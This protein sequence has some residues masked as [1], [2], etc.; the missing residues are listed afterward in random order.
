MNRQMNKC[1]A[2]L[3]VLLMVMMCS[4]VLV[5][6]L[7]HKPEQVPGMIHVKFKHGEIVEVKKTLNLEDIK[8]R[9]L[10][11]IFSH[12]KFKEARKIFKSAVP[13]KSMAKSRTGEWVALKDL[14]H[15]YEV[16]VDDGS[17]IQSILEELKGDERIESVSPV[18]Y[19]YPM[20]NP[21]N[22]SYFYYQ[23]GLKNGTSGRDIHAV[24]A[25]NYNTG[26]SNV[27]I[28]VIDGG[29]DYNHE[30][31]DPGN[32][33]RVIAGY[34][35][36]NNDS[37]PIDDI[38]S[39]EGFAGHGTL[40]AGVIGAM[41]D[42]N[43]GVAGIMWNVKIMPI[44]IAYTNGP[45]WD[46][47]DWMSGTATDGNIA[48]GIDWATNNGAHIIN[49]S[50]GGPSSAWAL[51]FIGNPVGEAVWNANQQGVL[52]IAA[53]G[54]DNSSETMYPAGF[55]PVMSVGASDNLDKRAYFSNW[56]SHIN[57]VAP[58][59]PSYNYS[60][61]RYDDYDY[62]GGTSCATPMTAGVAGLVLSESMDLGLN[63]TNDDVKHLIESTAD[64]VNPSLYSYNSKGWNIEMGYGRI[65]A[66][67][68]L[69][70]LQP[71]NSVTHGTA[72]GGSSSMT[73]NTHQHTFYNNGGLATGNYWVKQYK[74]TKTIT[75][76]DAYLTAPTVWLRETTSKGWSGA[77]P[78]K[79]TPYFNITSVTA[80]S[81]TVETFIYYVQ[82]NSIGQTINQWYPVTSANVKFNY[83]V[84]GTKFSPPSNLTASLPEPLRITLTWTDN[85]SVEDGFKIE[86]KAGSSGTW[87]QLATVG[88][89]V[90][91]YHYDDF[92][93]SPYYFR[94][95][96]YKGT[97]HT[98]YSNTAY[99]D[100]WH[101]YISGPSNLDF[102][103]RGTFVAHPDGATYEWR[104][105]YYG[106]GSWSAVVSTNQTYYR[107]MIYDDFELQC[108]ITKD[109][110]T[111]YDTHYVMYGDTPW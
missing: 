43:Q 80:S 23:Y 99:I 57:V 91:T 83:T 10:R 37:N 11:D 42:N 12:Y 107:T 60:T 89:N 65:N 110:R 41:T 81:F 93:Y 58:G 106:T 35:T 103:E 78:N 21:P 4:T 48:E 18:H 49:L 6:Q 70:A 95:R 45:W 74:V 30:D 109:G 44:K 63:L 88:A 15:W 77:N 75:F 56:G 47:F 111:V 31:L 68:A 2:V 38:P 98:N 55:P 61:A 108:K 32:R 19:F 54:N 9:E 96:A 26:N 66:E 86:K 36:A 20:G 79:E 25:W 101:G 16:K 53:M 71:P 51:F 40:V 8:A 105:R 85:S 17:D 72:Y 50:L 29:V 69:S 39:G 73:W 3:C 92:I 1:S 7:K 52:V 76:P 82:Y 33:S 24:G 14:S 90:T 27:K 67:A 22:D 102:K 13:G 84:V 100:P 5:A 87:T 97:T 62:F 28:A 94:V 59:H 46:P 34:D 104:Y 64:K